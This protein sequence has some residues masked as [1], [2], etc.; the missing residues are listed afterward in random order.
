[1]KN[2]LIGAAV[3]AAV[4][5]AGWAVA[6]SITG[7]LKIGA[8][9][10]RTGGTASYLTESVADPASWSV[11]ANT[12]NATGASVLYV[13][14]GSLAGS[15]TNAIDLY[16][17]LVD[18]FGQT[19]NMARVKWLCLTV[20]NAATSVRVVQLRPATTAGLTNWCDGA[21]GIAVRSPGAFAI[22]APDTTGYPVSNAVCDSLE[23]VNM[24]T[25]AAG[26]ELFVVGQ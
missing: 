21:T 6:D 25:N 11:T 5:L 17:A 20:T 7:T 19:V 22:F 26:Y 14:Q 2:R 1:M 24:S 4:L 10:T 8:T 15:E 23:V 13:R 9:L 12:T 18:S 3:T 16:G